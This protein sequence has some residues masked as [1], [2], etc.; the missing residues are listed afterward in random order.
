MLPRLEGESDE[1]YQRAA[2]ACECTIEEPQR[3]G[4]PMPAEPR[5]RDELK[6][7]LVA[8]RNLVQHCE[9]KAYLQEIGWTLERL[10][11]ELGDRFAK[12]TIR[13]DQELRRDRPGSSPGLES[14]SDG[15]SEAQAWT[16]HQLAVSAAMASKAEHG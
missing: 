14:D 8:L 13:L 4:V 15:E 5:R 2:I 7:L 12:L 3:H 6:G 11:Y 1:D 9:E 10:R 16:A